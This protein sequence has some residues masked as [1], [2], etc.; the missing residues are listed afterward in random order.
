V[1]RTVAYIR[2]KNPSYFRKRSI[3]VRDNEGYVP[4]QDGLRLY[5]RAVGDGDRTVIIPAAHYLAK[6]LE[7]LAR[8]RRVIFYSQRCRGQSDI[9][10]DEL[11]IWIDYEVPD[12]EAI[13]QHFCLE[14]MSIMGWAY[15]SAIVAL[16]AATYPECVD[17][18][19]LMCPIPPRSDA[20]YNDPEARAKK[21]QERIDPA[22]VKRLKEM[23]EQGLDISAPETYCREYESVITPRQMGRPEALA[24]TRS[25]PCAFPNEWPHNK[26][27]N[28]PPV[29]TEWDWRQQVASAPAPAL[30]LHG[31][32]D[33][34]AEGA[35][36]E[37][38]ATLPN[39][40]LLIIPGSG[41]FPHLEAPDIYFPAVDQFLSGE[42]PEGAKVIDEK[43]I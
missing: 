16:Y 5:Y 13:R 26:A 23:R 33:L 36:R 14:R 30:V 38:V 37:W 24:R 19:V 4:L 7:S 22:G 42:W 11:H 2:G 29:V 15:M 12:L 9:D 6:D 21:E 3:I 27:K 40:R 20:P 34:I 18:L 1:Q 43:P 41:H 39:A 10:P 31:T 35:S 25:D 8:G 32:E 17:R 28:F